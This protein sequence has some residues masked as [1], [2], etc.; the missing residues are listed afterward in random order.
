[1]IHIRRANSQTHFLVSSGSRALRRHAF[2]AR[3]RGLAISGVSVGIASGIVGCSSF[4]PAMPTPALQSSVVSVGADLANPEQR[5]LA[6]VYAQSFPRSGREGTVIG[7]GDSHDRVTLVRNGAVLVAFGCTGELLGETDP[8]AAEA[9]AAEYAKDD[10][11]SKALSPE[12]KTKVYEAFSTSLPGEV[13]ATDAGDAQGCADVDRSN[14]GS[15]LPQWIVPF[16]LKPALVRA[17]RVEVLNH[18]AG[19]LSTDDLKKMT[20]KVRDGKDATEVAKAW[21]SGSK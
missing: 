19:S 11:P 20:E 8:A 6:E 9:L 12:W 3:L 16:Y 14:P 17:D 18:I 21:L 13:M 10:N 4:E 15:S 1:M 5:V 2:S 7:I